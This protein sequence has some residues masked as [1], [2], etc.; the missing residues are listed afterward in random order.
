MKLILMQLTDKFKLQTTDELETLK[1]IILFDKD[2]IN[3]LFDHPTIEKALKQY[4]IDKELND[5]L[6]QDSCRLC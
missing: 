1:E 3:Y 6:C 2:I 4:L 5:P